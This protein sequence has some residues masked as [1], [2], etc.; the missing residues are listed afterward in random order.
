MEAEHIPRRHRTPPRQSGELVKNVR[1]A[2]PDENVVVELAVKSAE[3]VPVGAICGRSVTDIEVRLRRVV[4]EQPVAVRGSGIGASWRAI[5]LDQQWNRGVER[6]CRI[7]WPALVAGGDGRA[8]VNEVIEVE[9]CHPAGLQ[10]P[11]PSLLAEATVNSAGGPGLDIRNAV[12]PRAVD[13]IATGLI[14]TD[15]LFIPVDTQCVGSQVH[16]ETHHAGIDEQPLRRAF[17]DPRVHRTQP[18]I[19]HR[20][21]SLGHHQIRPRVESYP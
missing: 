13:E 17:D 15:Q 8:G 5:D 7:Q 10:Q 11:G 14:G 12:L 16:L 2:I 20:V 6:L 4:E 18:P 21:R 19:D 3:D 9:V 1:D